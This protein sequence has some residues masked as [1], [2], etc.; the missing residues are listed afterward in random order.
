MGGGDIDVEVA[1]VYSKID[2]MQDDLK[3]IK[4]T[5]KAA[6]KRAQEF[7][8]Y[9]IEQHSQ[10]VHST[11]RAHA[12]LDD[13]ERRLCALENTLEELADLVKPLVFQSRVL[14]WVASGFGVLIIGLLFAIFTGQA[15]LI[16][17]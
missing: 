3:E 11:N 17:D 4:T 15:H 5:V 10:V 7:E 6:D 8:K 16:F 12:R 2:A 14:I 1:V 13:Y 9:Y